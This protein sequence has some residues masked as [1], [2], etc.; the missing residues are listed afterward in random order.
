MG[1]IQFYKIKRQQLFEIA[2]ALMNQINGLLSRQLPQTLQHQE[3]LSHLFLL[4]VNQ[5]RADDAAEAIGVVLVI[6]SL[7]SDEGQVR[8]TVQVFICITG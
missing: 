3:H 1:F 8:V 5:N 4:Y 7:A 2:V 6:V